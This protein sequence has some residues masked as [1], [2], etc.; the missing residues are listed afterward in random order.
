[1]NELNPDL[2]PQ[3]PD[4]VMQ[5]PSRETPAPDCAVLQKQF[6]F[7]WK[8]C[9]FY[10]V[11]YVLFAYQNPDGIGSGIFALISVVC[12]LVIARRLQAHQ[13]EEDGE[14][15]KEGKKT[16][17]IRIT[18]ESLFYYGAAVLI[19]FGSCL[20]DNAFFLF[21]N[22]VG[23]FLLFSIASIKLFYNDEKWDFGKYFHTLID[24]WIQVLGALPL[25]FR[26]WQVYRR[27]GTKKLSPTRRYILIGIGIGLPILLVT[28][29]LLASADQIFSDLLQSIFDFSMLEKWLFT[30]FAQHVV[31]LPCGFLIYTLLLYL[32][33]GALCRGQLKEG[34]KAPAQFATPVAVTIFVMIDVVYVVFCGI[35][36]LFLFGGIPTQ[37]HLY[38]EYARKGFFELLFVALINFLLVLF[39]NKRFAKNAA[40]KLT[41][42]VTCLCTFVMI[43]SS[44]F[45]MYMYIEAY[46]LTFLRVFVFWFL[47]LLALFMVGMMV[48]IYRTGWNSFRYCLFV[49]TI[50]YT[51]FA[52]SG[53]DTAISS[54]NVAQFEKQ[55]QTGSQP[56]LGDYLPA[57]YHFSL[58]YAP[59]LSGLLEEHR[60]ELSKG[61]KDLIRDYFDLYEHFGVYD[62]FG[63]DS[64][65]RNTAI[66]DKTEAGSVFMW[67]HFNFMENTCYKICTNQTG[68]SLY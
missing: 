27:Q 57:H 29:L 7:M 64:L 47:F 22:H 28:T 56:A 16:V 45:R 67:K 6:P 43:V 19:S 50:L 68:V 38:A 65:D 3:E 49:L 11:C 31:L 33:M 2:T 8:I 30:E 41:M 23:S 20:T 44:A 26:H 34:I 54:Y 14:D 66:Y 48:S 40:L 58:A 21:F 53:V 18:G 61:N 39:C 63:D 5:T 60:E 35:Q 25:P 9:L 37:A 32:V 55:L 4:Q 1:M 51:V 12:L 17:S 42:T 46:H 10:G 24:Y 36:F 15:L 13:T 59:A 52:L 62:D